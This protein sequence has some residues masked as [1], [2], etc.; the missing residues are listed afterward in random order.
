MGF[1]AIWS[2]RPL[3]VQGMMN[4]RCT[5]WGRSSAGIGIFV[6]PQVGYVEPS[7]KATT[8]R[9]VRGVEMVWNAG[10][11]L[12][13]VLVRERVDQGGATMFPGVPRVIETD[14]AEIAPALTKEDPPVFGHVLVDAWGETAR[15]GTLA[16]LTKVEMREGGRSSLFVT[17]HFRFQLVDTWEVAGVERARVAIVRDD[18]PNENLSDLCD[19]LLTE[20]LSA[21]QLIQRLTSSDQERQGEM[22]VES[23]NSAVA[24]TNLV[25]SMGGMDEWVLAEFLGFAVCGLED[26]SIMEKRALL[27]GLSS[28]ERLIR[29]I[30]HLDPIVKNLAAKSAIESALS[31]D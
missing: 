5:G 15:V 9:R 18:L 16:I 13:V 19:K 24:L 14:N 11:Q 4:T 26:L 23:T 25:Q 21:T 30:D 1:I 3:A 6:R 20:L 31:P 12:D 28:K 2:G 17:G 29:A 7:G 8:K 27:G 10:R 22:M